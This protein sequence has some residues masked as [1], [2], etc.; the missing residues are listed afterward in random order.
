MEV[1]EEEKQ[2]QLSGYRNAVNHLKADAMQANHLLQQ[3]IVNTI[4]SSSTNE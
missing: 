1:I 3:D 2:H 4:S